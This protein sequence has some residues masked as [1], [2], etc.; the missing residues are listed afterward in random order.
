MEQAPQAF[1]Q[2]DPFGDIVMAHGPLLRHRSP[3]YASLIWA[4]RSLPILSPDNSKE[5]FTSLLVLHSLTSNSSLT[6]ISPSHYP[7]GR[8]KDGPLTGDRKRF[9]ALEMPQFMTE[10]DLFDKLSHD[11]RLSKLDR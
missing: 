11:R 3:S 5:I 9:F 6:A 4:H 1:R 10:S 2:P 8:P 7:P